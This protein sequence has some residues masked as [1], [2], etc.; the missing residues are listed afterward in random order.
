MSQINRLAE[1][2]LI[3]RSKPLKF[4]FD[5]KEFRGFEGDTLASA[6]I[7]NGV[8]LFGRSFKYHRPR[9]V[10]TAGSEEPNALVELRTGNRLEPNMR[11]TTV[12]LFDGLVANSQN[13]WPSLNFDVMSINSLFAPF[14]TAGFYYKTFMWPTSFWE[15]IYEPAIRRAAG[16]GK[17]PEGFD[18]DHY[19]KAF[20]HCDV[21]VIGAGPAGISAALAAGRAGA[22]VILCDENP[23]LGG[24]LLSEIL[25]IN[26]MPALDWVRAATIELESLSNVKILRRTTVFGLYDHGVYGAVERAGDHLETLLPYGPRQRSYR[27]IAKRAIL[28]SG[29]IERTMVFGDNDRPGIMLGSAVRTYVNQYAALPGRRAVVV[30]SSTDGLRTVET[31]K[32]QGAQVEAII[33]SRNG[34]VVQ[35]AI[36]GKRVQAVQ[37]RDK[38][39]V[40]REIECDLVSISNGWNPSLHLTCHLGSRPVWN[41]AKNAFLPGKLPQGL[42]VIGAAQGRFTLQ[43]ALDDGICAGNEAAEN[44]GFKPK[45]SEQN[46]AEPD[47]F[48]HQP[49]WRIK[50]SKGKCFVDFQHDVTDLDIELAN[51]EGF[52]SV[53]HMKRYTTLG[54]ATDQGKTANV[55]GLA[56]L[57][58]ISNRS[59]SEVGT[60][61]FRPPYTPVTLGAL[62]GHHRH[63]EF[64]PTRLTP[65]HQW[66]NERGAVFM[67]TGLWMRAQYFPL[68]SGENWLEAMVREVKGTRESVGVCDVSTLGKIDI[69]GKDAAAFLDRIYTGT[70]ST[71]AV[72][73]V[74]YGLMLREDGFVFDDGTVA[75]LGSNHYL[76]TTT[77]AGAAKVMAHLEFCHQ[78]LLPELNIAFT[79]VT[80]QWAQYSVAGPNARHVIEKLIDPGINISNEAFPYMACKAISI[81]GGIQARLFRISFSGE[82]SYE[83]GVP[84]RYG[85]ALIRALMESGQ[86]FGLIP[87]GLEALTTMRIEKGHVAGG[88]L[89]GQTTALDLGLIKMVSQK[90]D[91][92]GKQ[93]SERPAL[94]EPD[95]PILVGFKAKNSHTKLTSGAHFLNIGANPSL[96]N[97][98][99]HMT[100][101]TFSPSLNCWIGLGLL[102]N[103]RSRLGDTVR[104]VDF[105]RKTDE[106]VEICEPV[107]LDPTGERL[108][109]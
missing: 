68:Y 26:S 70:F 4:F 97:D 42:T 64:R 33:D 16:L 53:E 45:D 17:P 52:K 41:N 13:R 32:N 29:A 30:L 74:R 71:L 35:R 9:G 60:T 93:M 83:I 54:M 58:E 72:G 98:Q 75:R 47:I 59:I 6:L 57:G 55:A 109:G 15:K 20:A 102:K 80:E 103:G 82:L 24:R 7:A 95:R 69:Q 85:D 89:N 79:S 78:V 105:M 61:I 18:P 34:D 66:A 3:N 87:Y 46:L 10:L 92:I 19:E 40:V 62:A 8:S 14:L 90:K 65:S 96:E 50:G 36:G 11:A 107:F 12:E 38:N 25:Q 39:G 100:S 101:T 2:G 106:P 1:G 84:N 51:R 31:L 99:G 5:G 104:A 22:R 27:I 77:T 81:C 48:E 73:R 108:R 23:V 94:L 44:T 56:I 88:E 28:G 63:H 91:C 67:E 86:D 37:I 49:V 43:E 76:M 21:L